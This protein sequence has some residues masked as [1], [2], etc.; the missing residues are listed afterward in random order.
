MNHAHDDA[1]TPP[2]L[3]RSATI[4][5][6]LSPRRVELEDDREA[7]VAVTA[8]VPRAGDEVVV[9]DGET[10][11]F[12]IGVIRRLRAQDEDLVL[13][14]TGRVVLRGQGGIEL[15]TDGTLEARSDAASLTTNDMAL[16]ARVVRLASVSLLRCVDQLETR[17]RRLIE[18]TEESYREVEGLSQ[19]KAGRLRQ[20]AEGTYHLLARRTFVKGKKGVKVTGDQI[21][22]D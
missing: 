5:A 7:V 21:N 18:R 4:R 1:S 6:V 14:S 9:V 8:Y 17:A 22:L 2:V 16:S 10:D 11:P 20:V 13:E 3:A 12:V 15:E 19:T